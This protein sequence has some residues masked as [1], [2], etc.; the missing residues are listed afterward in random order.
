MS[1]MSATATAREPRALSAVRWCAGVAALGDGTFRSASPLLAAALDPDP[2]AVALV[3]MGTAAGWLT[4]PWC[5]ALIDRFPRRRILF[6]ANVVRGAAVG[7]LLALV[8][9]GHASIVVLTAIAFLITT[10]NV[11]SDA[12]AQALLPSLVGT[13]VA[14]LGPQNGKLAMAETTGRS[15]L[16]LPLG[17]AAFALGRLVPV[18]TH[19]LAFAGAAALATSLPRE[20]APANRP[21]SLR[22]EILGGLTYLVRNRP[23]VAMCGLVAAFNFA[24]N[25]AMSMFVL[26]AAQRLGASPIAYGLLLTAL[27]VGSVA[28]G[29]LGG[30][31]A[32]RVRW[33]WVQLAA[34]LAQG[35]AWAVVAG[36]TSAWIAAPALLLM[37][38]S[39]IVATVSVVSVRQATVPNHLL[40]R[41]IAGFRV[42]G[43]GAALL[44][45]L[46]GGVL[47]AGLGVAVVPWFTVGL[48][49]AVALPVGGYL[50][51][52]RLRSGL[53]F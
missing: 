21:G 29:W 25:V 10:G 14:E 11:L 26:Y 22:A 50:A 19:F 16:G 42:L 8:A 28:G 51:W 7:V 12:A 20:P 18:A 23:L 6:W 41:V 38:M 3:A 52:R 44:G 30:R 35:A 15:L 34:I 31:I 1:Q 46:L 4:G 13:A 24:D 43:N 48:F 5:G 39:S 2:R 33:P 17:S 27:A 36:T 32:A 45:A 37:G 49:G 53:D 9:T 40:G 47:A